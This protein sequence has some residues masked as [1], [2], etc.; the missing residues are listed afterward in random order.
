MATTSDTNLIW[1]E[2]WSLWLILGVIAMLVGMIYFSSIQELVRIWGVKEEYSYGYMIPFIT[3]F[4]IWQRKD[5]LQQQSF[6]GSWWGVVL[7]VFAIIL[8]ALGRL[9][10]LFLIEQISLVLLVAGLAW[11]LMGWSAFRIIAVPLLILFFMIPLP[12]FFLTEISQQLQFISS[13]IGVAVIRLFGISV[14]L[15][16]N[17]IDLGTYKLQVVEACSGLRYLFPLM[18]LGFIA[19]Y[20]F[21]GAFWKRAIIFLSTI[22]ITILMNSFRIG[23]IGVMVEYWGSSMAEGFLHDFEGWIVFMAC[24]ALLV[25][26]MWVL[27]MVGRDRLPLHEAFGIDLPEP[28]GEDSKI[29]YRKIVPAFIMSSFLVVMTA[30]VVTLMPDRIEIRP[31]RK[32]FTEFSMTLP[33]WQGSGDQLESVI[34]DELKLS[35]YLLADYVSDSGNRVNLYVAYYASQ[36]QGESAHS[37][38]TCL[39]GGGWKIKSL[40]EK[41]VEGVTVAGIPLYV[42]RALIQKG[43]YRQLVY[44]WFQQR[45]RIINNEYLVKWF[46]FWDSLMQ[47]RS[48]GALVR[49]VYLMP[50]GSDEVDADRVL[51]A[52]IAEAA[53]LLDDYIP[54]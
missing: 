39:P 10:T 12:Q 29:A 46:I 9:S 43:E 47:K 28:V 8:L 45:G 35:D 31:E 22:P 36:R 1:K 37:P 40:A 51:A 24:T 18:T 30:L 6:K 19:A 14:Y 44:Y 3:A 11:A 38:R 20:I 21:K 25:L 5:R 15:E 52:F 32:S 53:V 2:G 49:L 4:L 26:E 41:A 42:N 13:E 23:V 50:P 33:G 27:A 16:G 54:R 34:L 17:V 7:V 48:D